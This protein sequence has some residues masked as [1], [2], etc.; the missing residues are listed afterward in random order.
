MFSLIQIETFVYVLKDFLH[1][2]NRTM[3]HMQQQYAYFRS[4]LQDDNSVVENLQNSF[5]IIQ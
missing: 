2:T 1:V 3:E 5:H 4:K